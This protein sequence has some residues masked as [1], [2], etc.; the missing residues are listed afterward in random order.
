MNEIYHN[1]YVHVNVLNCFDLFEE[2]PQII[3][4]AN[5]NIVMHVKVTLKCE[6]VW[7]KFIG[8]K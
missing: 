2:N 7:G 3:L 6:C 8:I 4:P 5:K 1:I